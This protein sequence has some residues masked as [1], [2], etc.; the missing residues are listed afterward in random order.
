MAKDEATTRE[1][2]GCNVSVTVN[3][4]SSKRI[5]GGRQ[6][7]MITPLPP[8]YHPP[9]VKASL[10]KSGVVTTALLKLSNQLV[11]LVVRIDNNNLI[12][13]LIRCY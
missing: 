2:A 1:S 8:G 4:G 13:D 11:L 12:I 9:F 10:P 5:G 3:N 7:V 6:A